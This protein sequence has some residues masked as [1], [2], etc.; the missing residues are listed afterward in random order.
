MA[1][2]IEGLPRKPTV[3]A[4]DDKRANLI[5][6]DAVLGDAYHVVHASSGWEAISTLQ[7]RDDID[8]ILMDVHM[9]GMDGFEAA[10]HIKKMR[11]CEDIPIIFITAVY[12]EDP[13][14][15]KG[16]QSGGID[17]F[18]KPFDPEILRLKIGIYAAYR[19][20]ADALKERER[21]VRESEELVRAGRKLSSVLESL[22][23]GVLIADI[24]GRIC[25]AT[26]EVSRILRADGPFEKDAYGEILG[27]WDAAGQVLRERQGA[28]MRALRQGQSSHGEPMNI[29]CLD[30][31][32]RT[33]LCS[34]AP[35]R[36][37]DGKI[38]GAV[39]LIQDVTEPRKIGEDI[40][41]RV[42]QLVGLGVE[43]E[44]SVKPGT[45]PVS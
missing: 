31:S 6:I 36:G 29:R 17:Y 38:V 42:A 3:L 1:T 19:M 32:E 11:S 2:R 43:I 18:S 33:I 37:L 7:T 15:K 39:I 45:P 12:S 28:L 25:Q 8:V 24:E 20:R 5:A 16:Y 40:E 26:E 35:L 30:G 44:Q 41:H 10:A 13:F 34:I 4:V 14:V 27:W 22:P 21:Q 9:P 23:V